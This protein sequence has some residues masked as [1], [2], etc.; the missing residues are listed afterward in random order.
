M[1]KYGVSLEFRTADC[2]GLLLYSASLSNPDHTALEL[3]NGTV[4]CAQYC[5]ATLQLYPHLSQG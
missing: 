3:H 2:S 4:S 5:L 1:V